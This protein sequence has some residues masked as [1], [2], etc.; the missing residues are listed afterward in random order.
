[1]SSN[2]K[3][4]LALVNVLPVNIS[5]GTVYM[6]SEDGSSF[7]KVGVSN[8]RAVTIYEEEKIATDTSEGLIKCSSAYIHDDFM[9][10]T[11]VN[12]ADGKLY[13]CQ[14]DVYYMTPTGTI[15]ASSTSQQV[16]NAKAVYDF[17]TSYAS[18]HEIGP[19]LIPA[20]A[21]IIDSSTVNPSLDC[22]YGNKI[23]IWESPLTSLN[24][25]SVADS[26]YESTL[27][28]TTGST[29]AITIPQNMKKLNL[30]TFTPNTSY[31]ISIKD[32]VICMD[33]V[34]TYIDSQPVIFSS[35]QLMSGVIEPPT[36]I[37]STD[38]APV[39]NN[40]LPNAIYRFEEVTSITMHNVPAN[41]LETLVYFTAGSQRVTLNLDS[42]SGLKIT[43]GS[44]L[45]LVSGD[46]VM[47]IKDGV[48][49]ISGLM[50]A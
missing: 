27:Y 49:V 13:A 28:F 45:Y 41:S 37:D 25:D 7:I 12:P 36:V 23:Y 2:V 26:H 18:T 34:K 38:P 8:N 32:L 16:P 48:I 15:D 21:V 10:D 39:I 43:A 11:A 14:S 24:I 50:N 46:F 6:H 5:K 17:I 22:L 9:Q 31:V 3:M 35:S 47:S 42:S 29:F 30:V 40:T 19:S 1:M 44:A 4:D 20:P 33:V